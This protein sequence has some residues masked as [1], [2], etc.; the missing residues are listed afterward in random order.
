VL[1]LKLY[2]DEEVPQGKFD[3]LKGLLSFDTDKIDLIMKEMIA[4]THSEEPRDEQLNQLAS[5]L[6]I[7][8]DRLSSYLAVFRELVLRVLAGKSDEVVEQDLVKNGIAESKVKFLFSNLGNLSQREKEA[9][10]YWAMEVETIADRNHIEVMGARSD[11]KSAIDN[12]NIVAM[13]PVSIIDLTISMKEKDEELKCQIQESLSSLTALIT[14]LEE[15][16]RELEK[17]TLALKN[18][19]GETVVSTSGGRG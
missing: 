7:K 4:T 16:R 3:R 12:G 9:I 13:L 5:S 19:L 6:G 11:F 18:K 10:K 8:R 15:A 1:R 2:S 14:F 17:A